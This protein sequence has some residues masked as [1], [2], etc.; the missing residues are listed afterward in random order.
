MT[1]QT[2][3]VAGSPVRVLVVDDQPPFRAAARA[4]VGRID[5]FEV[6]AEAASGEEAVAMG[7]SHAPDLV[8]MDIN[9]PGMDGIEAT[10]R[11]VRGNAD[12]RVVLVSTYELADLPADA[13]SSGAIAYINKDD[14]GIRALRRVWE[15]SADAGFGDLSQ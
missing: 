11:I 15:H 2:G 7:L 13:R 6:V 1:D 10:R 5:G 14:F 9:M 3:R 12:I 8:L 4:V